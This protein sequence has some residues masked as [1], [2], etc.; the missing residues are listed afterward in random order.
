MKV[1]L[2]V[3][4]G[5]DAS[6]C[7][8]IDGELK[9]F[10]KE[11]RV[12][13]I[14]NDGEFFQLKAIDEVL[15]IAQISK[16]DVNVVAFT[17][18]YFPLSCYKFSSKTGQ[19]NRRK[20]LSVFREKK[21]FNIYRLLDDNQGHTIESLLNFDKLRNELGVGKNTELYF[22]NHHR[23]HILSSFNFVDWQDDILLVSCDG[24]GDDATY[25]A[26]HYQNNEL[27]CLWGSE[28]ETFHSPQNSA[29]S[30]GIAYAYST[31]K[32]GF[33]S[34]RHEGKITGLAA[35]GKPIVSEKILELFT[36]DEQGRITSTLNGYAELK[37][38]LD[39]LYQGL[40]IKDIAASIQ[41]ATE[42]L[43]SEWVTKLLSITGSR[44]VALSGGVFANVK[45]NQDI[46]ALNGVE[47]IFVFPA[48]G[49]DG[50][51]VGACIDYLVSKN[52]I[53]N[54]S[55]KRLDNVYLGWNYSAGDLVQAAKKHG[56]QVSLGDSANKTADLL[57]KHKVGAIYYGAMEMGPRALGARSILANPDK[58]DINDSINKRLQRTE[59]MP[60]APFVREVDADSTFELSDSAN[61]KPEWRD[62]IAA[63][64][65]VDGTARPQIIERKENPLYY[66][67]LTEFKAITGLPVLVNTS[68][69]AHEEPIIN[70][71]EEAIEALISD[72][73]DFLVCEDAI[74]SLHSVS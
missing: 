21:D 18:L 17:K 4:T 58:R 42:V 46:A 51:S 52:G 9:A 8:F 54:L 72:R 6:A 7:L 38:Q 3:H 39:K 11:E 45:L 10:C 33:K 35:F 30:I 16:K 37:S 27:N 32:C 34:N 2:G 12:S 56:L 44:Y 31:E 19:L 57:A 50:L 59:F 13:R 62:K 48:M 36:V 63:V 20:L 65:H 61:V 64:V 74:I 53:N 68:F 71:P 40:D 28:S 25:S 67:I 66:D 69:N 5:H 1:V 49:D 60:F 22:A 70:T 47:E 29:A 26:Y 15:R 24:G 41:S 43:I 14:K 73:V 55:R 23:S